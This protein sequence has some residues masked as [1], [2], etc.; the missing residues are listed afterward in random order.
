MNV[1]Q[2]IEDKGNKDLNVSLQT[3]ERFIYYTFIIITIKSK[4][5]GKQGSELAPKN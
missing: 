4:R 3:Q 5:Q 2:N 1:N